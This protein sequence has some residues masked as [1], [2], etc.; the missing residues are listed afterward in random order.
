MTAS[1]PQQMKELSE[2]LDKVRFCA[3]LGKIQRQRHIKT[4]R[5]TY[6]REKDRK[7]ENRESR[8]IDRDRHVETHMERDR[9][10]DRDS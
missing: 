1:F 9:Q 6:Y 7:T 10:T 2:V 3:S 8:Q 4:D 5:Q